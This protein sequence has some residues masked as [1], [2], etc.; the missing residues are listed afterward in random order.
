MSK[1]TAFLS[2]GKAHNRDPVPT[3]FPTGIVY[4]LHR[5]TRGALAPPFFAQYL[6]ILA[7]L[8][9]LACYANLTKDRLVHIFCL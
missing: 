7:S 6:F 8:H 3:S 5:L 1:C 2:Y 9:T 4:I